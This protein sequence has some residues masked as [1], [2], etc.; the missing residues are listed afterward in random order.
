[1]AK[2]HVYL[3]LIQKAKEG[4]EV[5]ASS[6]A[7]IWSKQYL[8]IKKKLADLTE[9][10]LQ[11]GMKVK[12]KAN[13]KYS[14]R[15]GLSL[16]IEDVDPGYTFGQFEMERQKTIE[17]LQKKGLLKKNAAL[18][19][20]TLVKDIAVISSETAA[21][22]Q[23]FKA[24][25]LENSFGYS[26]NVTLHPAA[27]QGHHTERDVTAALSQAAKQGYDIIV[28]IRGGGSK[29]DLSAFDNYNIATQIADTPAPVLT[30]IGHETDLTVADMVAHT[31]LK[32][33]TA[34]ADW[35]INHN[36]GYE[37]YLDELEL[38]LVTQ[39]SDRVAVQEIALRAMAEELRYL[40]M[41]TIS[42]H[43]AELKSM[44]TLIQS[45]K[46][47]VLNQNQLLLDSASSMLQVMAPENTL[48]RGYVMVKQEGKL[49]M[50]KRDVR[51]EPATLELIFND[52]SLIA[53]H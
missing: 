53:K 13:V 18:P 16:G 15:Y 44:T 2:G 46:T 20:P 36:A 33:P 29:L 4:D 48:A 38:Q 27:M 14:E 12:L 17:T 6:S 28:I 45:I 34:V 8:T 52:G 42:N 24:Q 19:L 3:N 32:T 41:S 22:Y 10:I 37:A 11:P 47:Q 1:M 7:Q 31:V 30:G 51:K 40:P 39:V 5:I 23:D 25:L 49:V 21:G 35:V 50:H 43:G 26:F 9:S